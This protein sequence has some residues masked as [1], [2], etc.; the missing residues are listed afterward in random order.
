LLATGADPV[1]LPIQGA[2]DSQLYYLRT[3]ADSRALVERATSAK[4]VVII[5]G[6]FISLEVAA[7]LRSRGIAVHVVARG[8]QPLKL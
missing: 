6:S 4:Q 2:S 5:G 1:K 7:S 8:R 3:Y